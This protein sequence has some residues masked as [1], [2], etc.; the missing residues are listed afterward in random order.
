M[1][2]NLIVT[3]KGWWDV[4]RV[5]VLSLAIIPFFGLPTTARAQTNYQ[6][7][8]SFGPQ[9]AGANPYSRLIEG[10]DGLLYGTTHSGGTAFQGTVFSLAK[11][12]SGY[13][14]L[15]NFTNGL[16]PV[17][18]LVEGSGG[19]LY[20][21]ASAGGSYN[22]GLVFKINKDGSGI[23]TL[24]DFAGGTGDGAVPSGDLVAGPGGTLYGTTSQG[25]ISN[26]GTVFRMNAGGTGYTNLHHFSGV[27]T[28][29]GGNPYA[30]LVLATDG[31]LYGT[32]QNGGSNNFGTVF[33][34]GTNG[35]GYV[36]L[37]HFAGVS[38][39]DG[40]LPIGQLIQVSDG[41][42]YGTTYYGGT[43][44]VGSIFSLNTNGSSFSVMLNFA[45]GAGGCQPWG[46]LAEGT[47]G[48]LYGT[49][50]LGGSNDVGTVFR[51]NKDGSGYTVLHRFQS[52]GG[53]GTLP[54]AALLLPASDG[55]LYGV[56]PI[57]GDLT[58]GTIFRLLSI[59]PRVTI[60][61]IFKNDPAVGL[62]MAGGAAGLTYNIQAT[63]NLAKTNAWQVIGSA[64]AAIDGSFQ[65]IDSNATNF[66]ARFYR[67]VSP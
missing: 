11:D 19:A 10:S 56:T 53:D 54:Q 39:Q 52:T 15:H 5:V 28:G 7:I 62:T 41:L 43:N 45:T 47:N 44:D 12:G 38:A 20:G 51:I 37:H 17:G 31:F 6:R 63:T 66:P 32:T 61:R 27:G 18:G 64:V 2:Y 48:I 67:S 9:S 24:H 42:L 59:S 35:T 25:G 14:V 13:F 1:P 36:V 57:G 34:I 29:D 16:F 4:R 60:T 8:K 49:T 46:G 26:V 58:Y 23:S 40:R 3:S 50:R 21:T 30:G 55:A 65:F 22:D 33:K